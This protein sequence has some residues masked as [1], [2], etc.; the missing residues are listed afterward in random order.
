MWVRRLGQGM[1]NLGSSNLGEANEEANGC[2][3]RADRAPGLVV[4]THR[5]P[6]SEETLN[7][8]AKYHHT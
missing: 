1:S 7:L 8:W 3:Q 2:F 4:S 6:A 5:K